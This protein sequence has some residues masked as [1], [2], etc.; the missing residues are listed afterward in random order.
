MSPG[1]YVVLGTFAAVG[2]AV[3]AMGARAVRRMHRRW[4]R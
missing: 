3:V 1:A 2:I 4:A